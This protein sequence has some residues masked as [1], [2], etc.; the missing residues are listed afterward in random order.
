MHV[1]CAL[2]RV[3]FDS[4]FTNAVIVEYEANNGYK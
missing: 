2:C 4:V 3:F 1:E